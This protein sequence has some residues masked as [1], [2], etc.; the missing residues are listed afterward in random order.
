M[1]MKGEGDSYLWTVITS[2]SLSGGDARRVLQSHQPHHHHLKRLARGRL[3]CGGKLRDCQVRPGLCVCVRVDLW[4][5]PPAEEPRAKRERD[6]IKELFVAVVVV[7][8]AGPPQA[9]SHYWAVSM[10][11]PLV[12]PVTD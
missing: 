5:L 2:S 3:V 10:R 11:M 1:A 9:V 12:I 7:A 6:D 4:T 8:A